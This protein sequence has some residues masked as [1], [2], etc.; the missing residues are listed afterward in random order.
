MNCV[1]P[2][3]AASLG[4]LLFAVPTRLSAQETEPPPPSADSQPTPPPKPAG[5]GMDPFDADL[6]SPMDDPDALRPDTTA[7]T[8]ALVPGVGN[9][10]MRHSYFVPGIEYGNLARSSGQ[11]QPNV[12]D[13]NSTSFVAGN[14][15][16]LSY[17]PHAQL[18]INYSGGGNFSTDAA[19]GRGYFHQL[20]IVQSFRFR[21]V[22]FD[23][24]D[25]FSYLPESQF[26]FGAGSGLSA[27]GINGSLGPSLPGL[28][29][30]YQPNQSI[31]AST[32]T[33]DSNSI[34]GQM[35]YHLSRRS[36]FTF[37]GSY[38]ILRFNEAGNIDV[39]D[40]IFSAGYNYLLSKKDTIGAVYNFTDYEYLGNPQGIHDHSI[41][42]AYGR[43]ITGRLALQMFIGP[44]YTTFALPLN[45]ETSRTSVAAGGN[46]SYA[47]ARGS[48]SASYNHGVGGGS[49]AFAGANTDTLSGSVNR[50]LSRVW[51]GG[52]SFGFSRNA[53]LVNNSLLGSPSAFDSWFA[54]ASL[55]RPVGRNANLSLGYTA[56]IQEEPSCSTP[57]CMGALVQHQISASMQWHTRPLV[58][59]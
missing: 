27:P 9:Q 25:Q 21:R 22:E 33:R 55:A 37:T 44:E 36:S 11:T 52:I 8:G 50:R 3:L 17:W 1:P 48:V 19:V 34:T 53:S 59:R 10:E 49:G 2:I 47:F 15:S 54:G 41:G 58:L 56:Y 43:K 28:Q 42:L 35:T 5:R 12:T 29:L 40:T 18:G 45:G 32:G 16:L 7:L 26:G 39:D 30:S 57:A 6:E 51:N 46:L 4:L 20:A 13:W 14:L 38:G 24:V 31:L 23:F